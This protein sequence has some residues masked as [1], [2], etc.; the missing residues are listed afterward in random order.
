MGVPSSGVPSS[1]CPKLIGA[2]V[3]RGLS[4]KNRLV[5]GR[6]ALLAREFKLQEAVPAL[7]IGLQRDPDFQV[8][9]TC[10][11]ALGNIRGEASI[12]ALK[13]GLSDSD[14]RVVGQIKQ[15]LKK[16]GAS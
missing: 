6:M 7:S 3:V 12:S 2:Y 4:D 14:P 5:W 9:V 1:G 15:E 11:H 8:R 16:L 13:S 10:A